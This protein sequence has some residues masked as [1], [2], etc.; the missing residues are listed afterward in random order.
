MIMKLINEY[1]VQNARNNSSILYLVA[2]GTDV[3]A[4]I[5]EKNCLSYHTVPANRMA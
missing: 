5:L 2:A 4:C 1:H 3:W